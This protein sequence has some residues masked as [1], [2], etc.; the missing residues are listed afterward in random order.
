MITKPVTA[1][2]QEIYQMDGGIPCQ[3]EAFA[4]CCSRW[5]Q[6]NQ[7]SGTFLPF[8][9]IKIIK[10]RQSNAKQICWASCKGVPLSWGV[11]MEPATHQTQRSAKAP[12]L[13]SF[14]LWRVGSSQLKQHQDSSDRTKRLYYYN[15]NMI[16]WSLLMPVAHV[17]FHRYSMY[18]SICRKDW[19]SLDTATTVFSLS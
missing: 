13:N 14:E 9:N 3:K 12:R 2:S 4:M 11:S 19:R 16:I 6:T 10:H 15:A 8:K 7:E 1:V 17:M 5:S 18:A